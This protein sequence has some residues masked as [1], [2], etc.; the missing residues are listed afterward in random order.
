[1]FQKII[2]MWDALLYRLGYERKAKDKRAID[3][4]TQP[5]QDIKR[6]N[7]FAM[8]VSKIANLACTETK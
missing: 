4:N 7:W 5:Y 8:A 1:M 3:P 2:R 6:I